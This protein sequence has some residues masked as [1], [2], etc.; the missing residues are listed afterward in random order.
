MHGVHLSRYK[1]L[2]RFVIN[3]HISLPSFGGLSGEVS[4]AGSLEVV[5]LPPGNTQPRDG[6]HS[7]AAAIVPGSS[8]LA[9]LGLAPGLLPPSA[10]AKVALG[11]G[12]AGEGSNPSPSQTPAGGAASPALG[13]SM[14]APPTPPSNGRK[15]EHRCEFRVRRLRVLVTSF[16]VTQS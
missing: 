5:E 1:G 2:A 10:L 13:S 8:A 16:R 11:A 14:E 6:G 15:A 9:G 7:A 4:A 3:M 12:A